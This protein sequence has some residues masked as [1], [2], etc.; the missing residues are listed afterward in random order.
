M[1]DHEHTGEQDSVEDDSSA[2]SARIRSKIAFPYTPLS[3]AEQVAHALQRRGGR[4]SMGELAAELDQVATS[5]AFRTKVATSRTFGLA[6]VRR[7]NVTLTDLGRQIVDPSKVAKARV[8]AFLA[9]QLYG[10]IYEE[11]KDHTLPGADGLERAMQR[12]GVSPKQTDRARQAFQK[13]A[14]QAG[15]FGYGSDRLVAPAVADQK[16]EGPASAGERA[17]FDGDLP[18]HVVALMVQL[19]ADGEDW[20]PDE[21]VRFVNAARTIWKMS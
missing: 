1:Q 18:A 16:V 10:A 19:L 21:T 9:V 11:F 12:L 20:T 7:G 4:A 6:S 15:F 5:G 3:D 17:F 13:S 2:S 14:T 8:D